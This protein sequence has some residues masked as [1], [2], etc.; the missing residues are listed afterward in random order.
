MHPK[1]P[2]AYM[3]I[4][5]RLYMSPSKVDYSRMINDKTTNSR[6]KLYGLVN[7]EKQCSGYSADENVV[8]IVQ[9]LVKYQC[10]LYRIS[11]EYRLMVI[12]LNEIMTEYNQTISQFNNFPFIVLQLEIE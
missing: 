12:E 1:H 6:V 3:Y 2:R 7:K 10:H 8:Q 11:W 5:C 4:V 9:L